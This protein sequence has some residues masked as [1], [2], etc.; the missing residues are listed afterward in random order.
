MSDYRHSNYQAAPY[1]DEDKAQHERFLT[2]LD[3]MSKQSYALDLLTDELG[4]LSAEERKKDSR[5]AKLEKEL[6][7]AGSSAGAQSLGKSSH[8]H[9]AFGK[10]A[11][12]LSKKAPSP[13]FGISVL[14]ATNGD[15][16]ALAATRASVEAARDGLNLEIIELDGDGGSAAALRSALAKAS[17]TH[18]IIFNAGDA[19]TGGYLA[20]LAKNIDSSHDLALGF[21]GR[22]VDGE[23]C[24]VLPSKTAGFEAWHNYYLSH[25]GNKATRHRFIYS[26]LCGKLL[27]KGLLEECLPSSGSVCAP[28]VWVRAYPKMAK[29]VLG[30]TEDSE[31][32]YA[33]ALESS[34]IAWVIDREG[35]QAPVE[36]VIACIAE[37]ERLAFDECED[38]EHKIFATNLIFW[39]I[40]QLK[41]R[42]DIAP[43]DE[44]NEIREAVFAYDGIFIN[45]SMFSEHPAICFSYCFSPSVFPPAFVATKRLGEID[46]LEG[47]PFNWSVF[48]KDMSDRKDTDEPFDK[49]F[50]RFAFSARTELG[51][52]SSID[53]RRQL[54]YG[55]AAYNAARNLPAEVI[56]SRSDRPGSH[57]A[58]YLYK[59]ANPQTKWYAEFS[60][61]LNM[62][63]NGV[64]RDEYE[65][66]READRELLSHFYEECELCVYGAADVIMFTNANQRDFML[67]YNRVKELEP[68]VLE[69]AVIMRQPAMD[70]RYND[71]VKTGYVLDPSKINI[72]YFGK[73]YETRNCE[74]MLGLTAN[75]DVVLHLFVSADS[76]VG[77]VAGAQVKVNSYKPLFEFLNLAS[78]MDYLYLNDMD[79]I[80]GCIPWLPSKYTD[81]ESAGGH[82]IAECKPGSPLSQ[83]EGERLI[84]VEG[85]TREFALGLKKTK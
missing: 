39:Q 16:A 14:I 55:V 76:K 19:I 47:A 58:A 24:K 34:E 63:N 49:L 64:I 65:S 73:F 78:K 20:E 69:H 84:K 30:F 37:L 36:S 12:R 46:E 57:I 83:M 53:R 27:R 38:L 66:L 61:P 50:A 26:S 44:R 60:D 15:A 11:K 21:L 22:L 85:I 70:A 29:K 6:G 77:D 1:A 17:K 18:I 42:Y 31:Q 59:K 41:A 45:R 68:R 25:I 82:I 10:A 23:V 4:I 79:D 72:A 9:S 43:E 8:R 33:P 40:E 48:S 2:Y 51:G 56:Y 35:E 71:L 28:A 54:Y 5:I 52:W 75:P 67:S 74:S 32:A 81:Y 13:T 3:E 62:S 80:Y 7:K